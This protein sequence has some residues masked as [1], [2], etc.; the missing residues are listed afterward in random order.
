MLNFYRCDICDH[1]GATFVILRW[2]GVTFV[3]TLVRRLWTSVTF[4]TTLVRRLWP[5]VTVW[6]LWSQQT[7]LTINKQYHLGTMPEQHIWNISLSGFFE[8]KKF[9][10]VPELLQTVK[11]LKFYWKNLVLFSLAITTHIWVKDKLD[12]NSNTHMFMYSMTMVKP[13]NSP[14]TYIRPHVVTMRIKIPSIIVQTDTS[15]SR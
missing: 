7:T 3:T 12:K 6:H 11:K 5:S 4:V 14:F 8:N 10:G 9:G 13:F 15:S 1:S 2:H